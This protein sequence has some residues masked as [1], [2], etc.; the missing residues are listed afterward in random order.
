MEE[1]FSQFKNSLLF[2]SVSLDNLFTLWTEE[3]QV[4]FRLTFFPF[5]ERVWNGSEYCFPY[6]VMNK[7]CEGYDYIYFT[8][9]DLE[10]RTDLGKQV[11]ELA[12]PNYM[13]LSDRMLHSPE[14]VKPVRR[15]EFGID[16]YMLFLNYIHKGCIRYEEGP[17]SKRQLFRS[18]L[19]PKPA[20]VEKGLYVKA[21][22]PT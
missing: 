13:V 17:M 21:V 2:F 19:L 5:I 7:E 1:Y 14:L 9:R 22:L 15:D 3:N 20:Y 11:M 16:L 6:D 18:Y 12:E 4:E 8:L 10:N